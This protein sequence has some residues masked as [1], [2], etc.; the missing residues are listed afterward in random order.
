MP[1]KTDDAERSRDD[2]PDVFAE[3]VRAAQAGDESAKGALLQQ[4]R[5]FL[6]AIANQELAPAVAAK[7][8]ASDVVQNTM[9]SAQRCLDDFRGS[10]RE[11]LLAWLR[12]I[13]LNDLKQARRRFTAEKR[14]VDRERPLDTDNSKG[15]NMKDIAGVCETPSTAAM[16]REDED[17]LRAA[18]ARLSP[19]EQAAIEMRNWQRLEFSEIGSHLSR[20]A[21]AARKLWSRAIVK[22]QRELGVDD[23]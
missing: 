3:L 5:P 7:V 18:M 17:Q 1:P 21:E 6:L 22:L 20:S 13:L 2:T 10:D 9:M 11:E 23:E 8:G 14:R 19:D 4:C 15:P 12:T 16:A